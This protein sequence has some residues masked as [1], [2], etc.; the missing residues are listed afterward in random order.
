MKEG[1][2]QRQEE[3][4]EEERGAGKNRRGTE[5]A[6]KTG[7]GI[8]RSREAWKKNRRVRNRGHVRI[9]RAETGRKQVNQ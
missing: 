7:R 3:A 9:R 1:D 4:H 6:L 8:K 5:E 2:Q